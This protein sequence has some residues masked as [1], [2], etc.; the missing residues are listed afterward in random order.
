[1]VTVEVPAVAVLLAASVSTVLAND[2]VTPLGRPE[3]EKA[4]VPVKPLDGVTVMVLDPLAPCA[5]ARLLGDA[6]RLKSWGGAVAV[7]V[8]LTVAV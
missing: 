6:D 3:A 8:R 5:I 1:M 2:A 7:T 4:T